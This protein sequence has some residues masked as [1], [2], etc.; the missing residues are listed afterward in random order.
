[1]RNLVLLYAKGNSLCI[2]AVVGRLRAF[3]MFVLRLIGFDRVTKLV[4]AICLGLLGVM[5]CASAVCY[6]RSVALNGAVF[7]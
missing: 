5:Q 4:L 3:V 7:R 6:F 1:M 2:S